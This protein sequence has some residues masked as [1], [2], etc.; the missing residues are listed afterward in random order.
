MEGR[1]VAEAARGV[2]ARVRG[3][4]EDMLG[5]EAQR[6]AAINPDAPSPAAR[7]AGEAFSEPGGKGQAEQVRSKPEDPRPSASANADPSTR[8]LFDAPEPA[9]EHVALDELRACAPE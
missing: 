2:S 4:V 8:G 1:S 3:L 9:R 7:A 5:A 6:K